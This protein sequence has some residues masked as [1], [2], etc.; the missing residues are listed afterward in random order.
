MQNVPTFDR[1]E[2]PGTFTR[3][4]DSKQAE[5]ERESG[6]SKHEAL[7]DGRRQT[8]RPHTAKAGT[9]P[10]TARHQG[11]PRRWPPV[12]ARATEL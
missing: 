10:A 5:R 3:R 1:G 6:Q 12:P 8:D 2:Y 11:L 7:T 4:D 9:G